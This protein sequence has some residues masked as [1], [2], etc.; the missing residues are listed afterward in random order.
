MKSLTKRMARYAS[1]FISLACTPLFGAT[2]VG[3]FEVGAS[4]TSATLISGGGSTFSWFNS[5]NTPLTLSQAL[6]D[7]TLIETGFAN[8]PQGTIIEFGFAP[9]TA[10]NI[11][12]ADLVL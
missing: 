1:I 9:V 7:A 3:P 10:T 4:A 2:I 6:T 11:A 12:G 5:E 8:A